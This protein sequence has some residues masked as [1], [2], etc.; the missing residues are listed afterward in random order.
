MRLYI[1]L[2]FLFVASVAIAASGAILATAAGNDQ[3]VGRW[4]I[5]IPA[6]GENRARYCWLEITKESA[7]FKGRFNSG[8]G[9]VFPL[10][11][12]SI[13]NGE[14]KFSHG[15]GKPAEKLSAVY[16]VQLKNGQ[17]DGTVTFGKQSP[18]AFTGVRGPEWP[19]KPPKR[20]SGK[21]IDLFNGKD[22]TGW[23][24]QNTGKPTAWTVQDGAMVNGDGA[25]NIYTEKRFRDFM[26][27][28]EFSVAPKSNSGVYLRGRYE[29]QVMDGAGRPLDVHSQGAVYGFIIP[30]S[31]AE[32]PAGEWQKYEI[33][34]V[35]NR[36]TVVYNGVKI[37]D[38]AE[39][40]GITGGA[41]DANE[42]D[43]G[44]IMLQGDHGLVKYRKV[45]LTPLE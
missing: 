27:E 16:R 2:A 30:S 19:A 1:C 29:I 32:K 34:L 39:I 5:T 38:N 45:Q 10:G 14:L 17:L 6:A 15:F 26:L 21:P 42:K 44:P 9:A 8:G 18:R 23:L 36:V 12:F 40:P 7:G 43:P 4:D 28:V 35:A 3:F 31:N 24:G 33:T 22:L 25:D 41:L 13:E 20:K 37:I 11:E